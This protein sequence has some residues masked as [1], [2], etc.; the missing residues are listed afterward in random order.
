MN[1]YR[2]Q[3]S[4]SMQSFITDL[5]SG[6]PTPGGG[7]AV[8]YVAQIAF[9]LLHKVASIL[10]RKNLTE[11]EKDKIVDIKSKCLDYIVMCDMNLNRDIEAYNGVVQYYRTPKN[12]RTNI[13]KINAFAEAINSSDEMCG[14]CYSG[15]GIIVDLMDMCNTSLKLDII[16]ADKLLNVVLETSI[17]NSEANRKAFEK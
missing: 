4:I 2:D 7:A 8:A 17:H 1:D 14:I 16:A 10:E 6:N 3:T 13:S 9:A 11:E 15:R 12:E 5:A